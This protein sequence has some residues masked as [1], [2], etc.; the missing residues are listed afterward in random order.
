VDRANGLKASDDRTLIVIQ[1]LATT[2][3]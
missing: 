3:P 2:S 1:R